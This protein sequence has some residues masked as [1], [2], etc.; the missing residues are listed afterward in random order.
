MI[1]KNFVRVSPEK[2]SEHMIFQH[3][4]VVIPY[5]LIENKSERRKLHGHWIKLTS[6]NGS[7]YRVASFNGNMKGTNG[8]DEPAQLVID[9]VGWLRL[10]GHKD[11]VNPPLE[12]KIRKAKFYEMA[13]AYFKHPEPFNRL[14]SWVSLLF[15][16]I[17][18]IIG[19]LL[20]EFG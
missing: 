9:W 5:R 16:L 10:H 19:Y 4:W 7:I 17:G 3:G 13:I 11:D 15:T 6:E 20:S 14:T 1:K 2:Y 8:N 12:V 18:I